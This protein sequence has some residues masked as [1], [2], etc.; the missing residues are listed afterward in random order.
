MMDVKFCGFVSV[1]VRV[2]RIE[3]EKKWGGMHVNKQASRFEK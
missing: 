2:T 1:L 3:R